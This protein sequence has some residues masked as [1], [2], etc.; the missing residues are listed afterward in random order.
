M[1]D[2]GQPM[3]QPRDA[4]P[5]WDPLVE[6]VRK[7]MLADARPQGIKKRKPRFRLWLIRRRFWLVQRSGEAAVMLLSLSGAV[8]AL[9]ITLLTWPLTD[10]RQPLTDVV[11]AAATATAFSSLVFSAFLVPHATAAQL[12]PGYTGELTARRSPWLVA[13]AQI[14]TTMLL[15]LLA[16]SGP[17]APAAVAAGLVTAAQFG[18]AWIVALRLASSGD[19]LSVAQRQAQ[20][21]RRSCASAIAHLHATSTVWVPRSRRGAFLQ[22]AWTQQEDV[23]IVGGFIRHLRSGVTAGIT[24][25][26]PAVVIEFWDGQLGCLAD[27]AERSQGRVGGDSP[28]LDTIIQTGEEL[29]RAA[30]DIGGE[31]DLTV[32]LAVQRLEDVGALPYSSLEFAPV[33]GRVRQFLG[34]VVELTWTDD[35]STLPA[36]AT[37]GLGRLGARLAAI[38]GLADVQAILR[39]LRDLH[40]QA[41]DARRH[42][43]TFAAAE[44][45]L[46]VLPPLL[47]DRQPGAPSRTRL[48]ETWAECVRGVLSDWPRQEVALHNPHDVFLP[49]I[50]LTGR[51]LQETLWETP[52]ASAACDRLFE[53]VSTIAVQSAIHLDE[54]DDG[55]R[56][57][58]REDPLAL[59]YCCALRALAISA[60]QEQKVAWADQLARGAELCLGQGDR[61]RALRAFGVAEL[62][63]SCQVTTAFLAGDPSKLASATAWIA[64]AVDLSQGPAARVFRDLVITSLLLSGTARAIVEDWSSLGEPRWGYPDDFLQTS[65]Q[66]SVPGLNRNRVAAPAGLI[67]QAEEWM[68]RHLPQLQEGTPTT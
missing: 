8:A 16:A 53:H 3:P 21:I 34:R 4:L 26:Q 11:A 65:S 14:A 24:A 45:I 56:D 15:F 39:Q 55:L 43:I 61:L 17:D 50:A 13:G 25:R 36:A 51:G 42:H 59:L 35:H 44:A 32:Q 41:R 57:R 54:I 28:A 1:T 18:F 67:D 63:W 5:G 60:S 2:V 22:S 52:I 66:G 46:T 6:Q 47:A 9:L 62:Y 7:S 40:D 30:S 33:R 48:L 68:V 27:Y 20:Y 23:K 12:A 49:G 19:M 31:M 10:T 38:E 64:E 37:L 58:H 29:V